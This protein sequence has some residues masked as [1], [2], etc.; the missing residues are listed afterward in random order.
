MKYLKQLAII[1]LVSF[2]AELMGYYIP[3]PVPGSVYGLVLMFVLLCTGIIK[4]KDV[5]N[6]ADFFLQIMPFLF[7]APTVG[8]ITSFDIIKGSVAWLLIICFVSAVLTTVI[9]G[10]V[11]QLVIWAQRKGKKNE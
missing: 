8:I 7:V 2:I 3:L 5:E 1:V 4:L 9:T 6:V 11:A 10:W